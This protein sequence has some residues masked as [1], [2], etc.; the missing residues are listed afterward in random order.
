MQVVQV[1]G[2]SLKQVV[3]IR[4]A[5]VQLA[6]VS[7]KTLELPLTILGSAPLC[8]FANECKFLVKQLDNY[9]K[10]TSVTFLQDLLGQD[11]GEGK[12]FQSWALILSLVEAGAFKVEE[13]VNFAPSIKAYLGGARVTLS[14]QVEG[15][16][17]FYRIFQGIKV[18]E[19]WKKKPKSWV[20]QVDLMSHCMGLMGLAC[21][22]ASCAGV[23]L[24]FGFVS[25]IL[26]VY[27]KRVLKWND[28]LLKDYK[29][30]AESLVKKLEKKAE[31]NGNAWQQSV[32]HSI[33]GDLE[34]MVTEYD[35]A[36]VLDRMEGCA[37]TL[38]V[39]AEGC[40]E[41]TQNCREL[42]NVMKGR[43]EKVRAHLFK[44]KKLAHLDALN[45]ADNLPILEREEIYRK[46][47]AL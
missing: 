6:G 42:A 7:I 2:F 3:Q 45:S 20:R 14:R 30:N 1:F 28:D 15:L 31:R 21:S 5:V 39:V 24:V 19:K 23:A 43:R 37:L 44:T 9:Q 12:Q 36:R 18:F 35:L 4:P 34:T 32:I 47:L 33:R 29:A 11:S 13:V 10:L 17:F 16:M 40:A 22:V 8:S 41:L 26:A 46:L 25:M 38:G 27:A